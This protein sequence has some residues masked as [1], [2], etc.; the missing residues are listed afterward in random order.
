MAAKVS[1]ASVPANDDVLTVCAISLLAEILANVLH[2]G[3][4]HAATALLTGTKSGV[5][6]TV[7]WSSDVDSRL[8]AAG[9]NTGESGG[10]HGLL[11]CTA[12]RDRR[13]GSIT[14]FSVHKSCVQ[15]LRRHRVFLLLRRHQFRR[16][17]SGNCRLRRALVVAGTP[18]R[19]RNG[20]VLRR[21]IGCGHRAGALRRSP[22][23]RPPSAAETHAYSLLLGRIPFMRGW[24]LEPDWN[25]VGV[26]IR[27]ARSGGRALRASV[28][29]VLHSERNRS[30]AT[31]RWH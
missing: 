5:L 14:L 9:G 27:S 1:P 12:Q 29:E 2:E 22:E 16:L 28:V 21:R 17:G 7:A 10:R 23:E 4:G 3:L 25:P 26:A 18:R 8:V 11:D 30:R 6:T 20:V 31:I 13:I 19:R 15:P 24:T